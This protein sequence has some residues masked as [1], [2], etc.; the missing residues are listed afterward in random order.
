[1]KEIG[2]GVFE[3]CT[4]LTSITIPDSVVEIG[5]YTFEGCI[6]LTSIAIPNSVTGIGDYAFEDCTGLSSIV[7][8][9]SVTKIGD[10][11][12]NGCNNLESIYCRVEDPTQIEIESGVEIGGHHATL[13]VPAGK[14]VVA[15]YKKKAMWKKF[16]AIK[17][18][19]EK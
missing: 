8:G 14:G 18:M 16:A 3:G 19:E 6:G 10:S 17:P 9:N 4:G 7:I 13:Y 5:D 2:K 12:F 15:A 1:M 11:I